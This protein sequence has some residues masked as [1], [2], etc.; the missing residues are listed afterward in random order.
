MLPLGEN[1]TGSRAASPIFVDFMQEAHRD[2]PV[3]DFPVPVGI[4]FARI[5]T[6]TG[7]LATP[8]SREVRFECFKDGTLPL[9]Q[10]RSSDELLL[11]E[12]Y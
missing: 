11:K 4:V 12:V 1:E 2:L 6:Q 3:M 5:D 9:S 10:E 8:S 7:Q